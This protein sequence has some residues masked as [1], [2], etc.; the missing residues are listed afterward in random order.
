MWSG[1]QNFMTSTPIREV[2]LIDRTS[3]L[4]GFDQKNRSSEEWCWFKFNNLGQWQVQS[5]KYR[6]VWRKC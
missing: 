6:A 2:N 5:K 1:D 4:Q 3:I